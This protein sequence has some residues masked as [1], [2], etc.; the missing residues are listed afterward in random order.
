MSHSGLDSP[1]TGRRAFWGVAVVFVASVLVG[2]LPYERH[3]HF[4]MEAVPGFQA[5]FGLTGCI[6]LVLGAAWLRT[7]LMRREDYYD[8]E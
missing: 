5:V 4:P 2:L 3:P 7:W 6:G 1:A 8:D